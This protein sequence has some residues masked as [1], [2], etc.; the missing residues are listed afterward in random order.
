MHISKLAVTESESGYK[1]T[2]WCNDFELYYDFPLDI[3]PRLCA[4]PF[5]AASLLSAMYLNEDIIIDEEWQISPELLTNLDKI[6]DIFSRWEQYL[7]Y[8]L[9]KINIHGGT[10]AEAPS[11]FCKTVSFFSGGVDG[12]HTF[13]TNQQDIDALL[14]VKGIDMQLENDALFAETSRVNR[15]YLKQYNKPLHTIISNVRFLGHHFGVKWGACCGGGLSSIALAIGARKCL[16][17]SGSSYDYIYPSGTNY[18]SDH[19]WGNQQTRIVHDGAQSSRLDKIR[20]I[21]EDPQCL[22]ILRVCW[23]DDGY[24]CGKCEKCLRTMASL[25]ALELKVD[26]FPPLTDD[27]ARSQ[28]AN[29]KL[30]DIHDYQFLKENIEQAKRVNDEVLLKALKKIQTDFERRKLMR[31]VDK[32]LFNGRIQTAKQGIF[33]WRRNLRT[34][35]NTS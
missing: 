32:T 11:H 4:D 29:I 18:I 25:R 26:T 23:H 27:V 33:N 3:K 7:G 24:N 21:A 31:D 9:N 22:K 19:L 13:L 16:I 30:Y 6:Q 12:S 28:L 35:A 34:N 17:A 8:K 14:F 2:G 20:A 10:V 15:E 5:V 1:L